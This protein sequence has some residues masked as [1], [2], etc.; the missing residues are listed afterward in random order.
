MSGRIAVASAAMSTSSD[1]LVIVIVETAGGMLYRHEKSG[2]MSQAQGARLV[3]A[4]ET[5]GEIS[6]GRWQLT[7]SKTAFFLAGQDPITKLKRKLK[8]E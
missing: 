3:Q 8:D 4:I 6:L 1:G 5:A 7:D 2:D